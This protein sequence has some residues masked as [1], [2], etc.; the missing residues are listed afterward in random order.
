MLSLLT[1][2]QVPH[3]PLLDVPDARKYRHVW[4]GEKSQVCP[5]DCV[6]SLVESHTNCAGLRASLPPIQNPVNK[7]VNEN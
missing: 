3:R 2:G 5:T 7:Q 1:Q 4:T 6:A